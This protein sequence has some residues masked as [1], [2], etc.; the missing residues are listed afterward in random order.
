MNSV[1]THTLNIHRGEFKK[2]SGNTKNIL[3]KILSEEE[4]YNKT[5]ANEAKKREKTEAWINRF[6]SKASMATRAQS[7]IKALEKK[8]VKEKLAAVANLDFKFNYE[9][10]G[11]K[12]NLINSS[13]LD[14][15]YEEN[16]P[17]INNLSFS[18]KRDDKIC[19]IGK[20][21]KGKSTLLKLITGDLN[22]INGYVNHHAKTKIGYFGQMN[23]D[24]LD[25]N[26]TIYKEIQNCV[27]DIHETEVR[28]TCANM[29]FSNNLSNKKINILS[30]GEKSR[31]M[32]G[33]ILIKSANLLLLDEPTNHLDLDS[34]DS[35]LS[36]IKSFEGAVLMVTHDEYF[37]N[38]VANKLIVFD[39]NKVSI[40][41]GTYDDFL[42]KV[43]WIDEY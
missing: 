13:K 2:T 39:D 30:G 5:V 18:I 22:P 35:L 10:Y 21:G 24:R 29:M 25:P 32:L 15:F 6:K 38:E 40:F 23:I 7:K 41:D 27:P 3:E 26:N 9:P 37:L 42:N 14:F 4:I 16:N 20:N 43:G 8:E 36:A 31:V 1:I 12:E 33:K 34:C 28:K 17:L 19:I 11:S